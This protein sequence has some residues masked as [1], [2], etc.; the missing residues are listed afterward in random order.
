M[1][2]N[3]LF[4]AFSLAFTISIPCLMQAQPQNTILCPSTDQ[5]SN[6]VSNTITTHAILPVP[7][8][9]CRYMITPEQ[10][11]K[12]TYRCDAIKQDLLENFNRKN[13]N[14]LIIKKNSLTCQYYK[15]GSQNNNGDYYDVM[16]TT[17]MAKR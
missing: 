5:I 10:K 17:R 6:A 2:I 11:L 8:E 1:K 9:T 7:Y 14:S 13:S 4:K 15:N 12:N 16:F 3:T